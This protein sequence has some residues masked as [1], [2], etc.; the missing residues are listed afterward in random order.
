LNLEHFNSSNLLQSQLN[1]VIQAK[2]LAMRTL[3]I[4]LLIIGFNAY[5]QY[6]ERT[7]RNMGIYLTGSTFVNTDETKAF[8]ALNSYT[9]GGGIHHMLIPGVFPYAGY[10]YTAQ[11][12]LFNARSTVSFFH[13]LHAGVLL[14]KHLT[15]VHLRRIGSLCHYHALGIILGPE[16]QHAIGQRGFGEFSAQIGLS[17]YH[18]VSGGSKRT[19]GN[20]FQYDVFYRHGFTPLL[21]IGNSKIYSQQI[22][23]RMR[24][25]KHKVFDFLK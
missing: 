14:D 25:T 18:H 11:S 3:T 21:T 17:I 24:Y 6:Y 16:Y 13:A 7:K 19:K 9:V 15:K 22:G 1:F 8:D 12:G 10:R 5:A 20:T 23:L 4:F 2:T